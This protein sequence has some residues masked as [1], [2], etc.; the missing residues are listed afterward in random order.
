MTHYAMV[1][2]LRLLVTKGLPSQIK[3]LSH[4]SGRVSRSALWL[5]Q[6]TAEPGAGGLR[7]CVWSGVW[8]CACPSLVLGRQALRELPEG[9]VC[10]WRKVSGG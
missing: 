10:G 6:N 4:P 5:W 3:V 2:L 7:G 1:S 9:R 8:L